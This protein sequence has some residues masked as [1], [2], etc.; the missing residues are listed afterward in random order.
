MA[1]TAFQRGV[2]E[3]ATGGSFESAVANQR[4]SS[5]SR[6][7]PGKSSS[8]RSSSRSS[9]ATAFQK[10]IIE[11]AT[12]VPFEGNVAEE[13]T[14]ESK[15]SFIQQVGGIFRKETG[16][17]TAIGNFLFGHE[18]ID[19]ETGER[20]PVFLTGTLPLDFG[21][22][23]TTAAGAKSLLRLFGKTTK[24]KNAAK[25]GKLAKRANIPFDIAQKLYKTNP[26]TIALTTSWLSKFA[27]NPATI[28]AVIGSYPFANFIK[29]EAL[30]QTGFAFTSAEKINDIAGMEAAIAQQKEILNPTLWEKI[31]GLVPFVNVLTKLKSYFET[32]V[33]KLQQD[34]RVLENAKGLSEEGFISEFAKE[35]A[36]AR[37]L[38]LE[39]RA[40]DQIFF[41][42]ITKQ[43]E[44]AKDRERAADD[45]VWQEEYER[46]EK[47]KADERAADE[48][49]WAE[50]KQKNLQQELDDAD[51]QAIKDW[52]AGKSAL[53][54][55]WLGL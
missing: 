4:G 21:V 14:G 29:E 32:A 48:A 15:E 13:A 45:A 9:T 18:K 19:P 54:F 22:G 34:E 47:R 11:K 28:L 40:E 7:I 23:G 53:N 27:R 6:G 52:N 17:R 16:E 37:E 31:F 43:R 36:A 41:D 26:K 44:Q 33:V 12:G 38:K 39:Q 3:R 51:K 24:V 46:N 10:K 50:I 5:S 30:Q 2:I 35:Q 25:I 55:K 42:D 1:P 20:V 8:R 49:Y